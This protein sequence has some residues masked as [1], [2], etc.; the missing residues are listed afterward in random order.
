MFPSNG[1]MTRRPL[2]STGSPRVAFPGFDGTMRRSDS[3]PPFPPRFVVLRLAVPSRAPVFVSP[4]ARR[5]P[6]ARGFAVWQPHGQMLR[7]GDGRA[8][9]VPGEPSCAYAL[10]FD[11]GGTDAPGHYGA[12]TRPPLMST[13]KAPTSRY[14]RGSIARPRHS[15]S[16]L[17]RVGH[18][19]TTQ[20]SLPAA[21]Q[22]L[23]GGIGYPQGSN[24]RFPRCFLHR[25]LL[26]QALPVQLAKTL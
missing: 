13:T 12:S 22:A 21:G 1:S 14:F 15:L 26:P 20:D 6:R 8:S 19:T 16:T 25:F 9:Q 24:E 23:P 5:R 17:R 2:P 11:P 10:F 18:P 3:L 4:P 7:D